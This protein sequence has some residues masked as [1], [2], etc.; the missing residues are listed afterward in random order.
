MQ[1]LEPRPKQAAEYSPRSH[2]A[3]T[4]YIWI[5]SSGSRLARWNLSERSS[6]AK[7][8]IVYVHIVRQVVG[9]VLLG[10]AEMGEII[11]TWS[12]VCSDVRVLCMCGGQSPKINFLRSGF[13]LENLPILSRSPSLG[14]L[15]LVPDF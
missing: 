4:T 6:W 8:R 11:Q 15:P 2:L 13:P 3:N 10:R 5:F 9:Y 7:Y 14:Y 12:D 1:G